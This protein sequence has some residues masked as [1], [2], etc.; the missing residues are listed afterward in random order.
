MKAADL[1]HIC[2]QA[3]PKAVIRG[4]GY[5]ITVLTDRLLRLE[6]EE[7]GRFCDT[8]TQ[9][10]L[11]RD[12][13]VPAFT[14]D[15][16]E[17]GLTVET[18]ALRLSY[19]KRPFSYG[20]L[21]AALKGAYTLYGSG[22]HYGEPNRTFGGTA[23]TLDEANGAIPLE[24]GLTSWQGYAVLD[25]SRSMGMDGEGSLT[26]A[27]PYGIDLYLFA[28]GWDFKGCI[29]DFLRLS[30]PAPT[31]PRFALGN[32]WSRFYP[33]TQESYRELMEKFSAEG[34]P[35]SVS[36]LDMNWHVTEIDPKYGTGWTGY[37]WD[38]CKFPAP[39][40]LLAWLHEHG[41][42]VTLNDHPADG[43]RPC[44]EQYAQMARAMGDDPAQEKPY[45]YDA[46]DPRYARAFE[47]TVLCPLERQG[48][49]FWWL[50]WQ[51]KGGSSDPGVDPLFTLNHTRYL[52]AVRQGLP[53]LIL[54]R[55]GGP[56]SHRYPIGFSGDT[57]T[58]W[59]SLAFQ[60][61]FTSTASNIG[62]GWWSH[63]IGGHML[64]T[65]DEEL[66]VRW[67]QFGV[68]SP[69][70]RLHCSASPF[71][72]KEPWKYGETESKVITR[73]LRL[74]HQL[75]PYLYTMNERFART[76]E[77]LIS[78]MY[79][80]YPQLAE[81]Y[82]VANEYF[83]GTELIC[84]PVTEPMLLDLQRAAVSVWL[85]GGAYTDIFTGVTYA[86]G[87]MLTMYRPVQDIPVLLKAGGILPM[88]AECEIETQ[89]PFPAAFDIYLASGADG[90]FTLYE[91]DGESLAYAEGKSVRTTFML[92]QDKELRFHIHAAK[93]DRSLLPEKRTYTLHFLNCNEPKS[94]RLSTGGRETALDTSYTPLRREVSAS[95][96]LSSADEADIILLCEE[97]SKP[98]QAERC[99]ALLDKARIDFSRKEALFAVIQAHE[100][101]ALAACQTLLQRKEEPA[102]IEALLELLE[103]K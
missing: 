30:G 42:H 19:D 50:D 102:L 37:T 53:P 62:Y 45:P 94:L 96:S 73:Y 90:S 101:D 13:P 32:W 20:G 36:V 81:A 27:R 91:D 39:E 60:P 41:L 44:E 25:D 78:P 98:V 63:D 70:M 48:V 55:Y 66:Q 34:I 52:H 88:A 72:H 89:N 5:R 11:C 69:I 46:A 79:H 93:G 31:L 77:A 12:F 61:W 23:R 4:E 59:R 85:P 64:G 82:E 49:D 7:D 51:Q 103:N 6:Y 65:Y 43:V 8:A 22:W 3:N 56:G 87:R 92:W 26:P 95:I 86:G 74:R 24:E 1:W 100:T 29:R 47:E 58:T 38:R 40:T 17:R 33:Y 80:S 16:T 15:E 68:F 54:S 97:A 10:A 35:L 14:V 57:R 75:I 9:M 67:V 28:Y 2:P 84:A 71:N 76:G 18:E 83:F 21:T 99:F